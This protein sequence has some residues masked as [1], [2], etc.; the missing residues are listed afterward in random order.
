MWVRSVH[1]WNKAGIPDKL[2]TFAERMEGSSSIT[3]EMI[4]R[5]VLGQL[6][7]A[8]CLEVEAAAGRDAILFASIDSLQGGL[9]QLARMNAVAPPKELKQRVLAAV[10]EIEHEARFRPP[11]L[12]AGS[13]ATDFAMW[14]DRP[15]MVRPADAEDIHVIP[16]AD[17]SDGLSA[18]VW[19]VTGSPE[20]THTHCVEKFLILEGSCHIEFPGKVIVL[21]PGDVFSIPLHTPHT[22]KVTSTVPCKIL[23]QRI[24]A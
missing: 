17:N 8:E 4:E 14:V 2:S 13:V 7:A 19:L 21:N 15:E 22:V 23:L 9:E 24:A 16:F 20:E 11:V 3:T 12:H 18:V 10:Q 5:Y 6:S 1:A